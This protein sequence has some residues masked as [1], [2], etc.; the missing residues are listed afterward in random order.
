MKY[1]QKFKEQL[2]EY[3]ARGFRI[4]EAHAEFIVY[5]KHRDREKELNVLLP[6]LI[7]RKG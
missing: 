2:K 4:V 5:W 3:S 7:L 1:A 6:R